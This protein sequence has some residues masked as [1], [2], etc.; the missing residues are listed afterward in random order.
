MSAASYKAVVAEKIYTVLFRPRIIRKVV[1]WFLLRIIPEKV[2]IL[3]QFDLVLNPS[4]PVLS[5]AVTFGV[6]EP[7]EQNVFK[8]MCRPGMKVL[9]IGAN[10]GLYTGIAASQVGRDGLVIAIEPH[11]ESFKYLVLMCERNGF[12]NVRPFNVAAGDT[13]KTIELFLTDENKAD[14]RIYDATGKRKRIPTQM[15]VIDDLLREQQIE[16]VDLIKMDIQGAEGLALRGLRQTLQKPGSLIVFSE[17]WPW[18]L[19]QTEVNP[20]DVLKTFQEFGFSAS[21]IQEE[22][23]QVTKVESLDS[24]INNFGASEYGSAQMQRSHTNLI[25]SRS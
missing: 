4:D 10:V 7:F 3:G 22:K 19:Q 14:S 1:H 5:A 15:V 25:F 11:P 20:L 6:Y 13:N 21:I 17:F 16:R 24:L 8:E 12:Q 2:R 18:G 23:R 9:D